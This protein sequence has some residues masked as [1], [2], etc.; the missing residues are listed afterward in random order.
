M[1]SDNQIID[2]LSEIAEITDNENYWFLKSNKEKVLVCHIDT[3][4]YKA[5]ASLVHN[6]GKITAYDKKGKQ[7]ILG[8][9]DRAG[10]YACLRIHRETG[11]SVLF[12]NYEETGGVG[13]KKFIKDNPVD[14][15]ET[16]LFLE[17]DRQ[18]FM[19]YVTYN[20]FP[21]EIE[22]EINSLNLKKSYGSY[23]DIYDLSEHY[24]IPSI[25]L[26]IGYYYQHTNMEYLNVFELE[27]MIIIAKTILHLDLPRIKI[28][29]DVINWDSYYDDD[30][31]YGDEENNEYYYNDCSNNYVSIDQ[32]LDDYLMELGLNNREMDKVGVLLSKDQRFKDLI[33]EISIDVLTG[34][35]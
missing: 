22:T 28:E 3:V 6:D 1:A 26:G 9:D 21:E 2:Y 33:D 17:L 13:V 25:N 11:Y 15:S 30:F 31:Y 18:G 35:N 5:P 27:Q 14:F 7:Q 32:F 23:S 4:R 24:L 20:S 19:E 10:V 16:T 34:E 12:T 29:K 8:A